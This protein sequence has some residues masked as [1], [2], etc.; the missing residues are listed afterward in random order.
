LLGDHQHDNATAAIAALYALGHVDRRFEV[1]KSVMATGIEQV[2]WPGRLQVL[3][4]HPLVV[5]DGAHNAASAGV[6]RNS[7]QRDFQFDRLLLVIGLSAGKDARGVLEA[8]APRAYAVHLTRSQHERSAPP[9]GLAPLVRT[10]APQTTVAVHEDLPR[11]LE[12]ALAMARPN[13]MVLVTG[14]LFLVGEAL[15]WWRSSPQ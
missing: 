13:D 3:S 14:S 6:V 11:A 1:P 12:A 4:E 15:I 7:L 5:L 9:D 10:A 2:V 8:L